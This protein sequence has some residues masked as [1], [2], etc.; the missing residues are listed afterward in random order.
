M[1]AARWHHLQA[2]F[3]RAVEL[4]GPAQRL[5][6]L[7]DRGVQEAQGLSS[8]PASAGGPLSGLG[9]IYQKPGKLDRA[10]A[11]LRSGLERRIAVF[12]KDNAETALHQ[13]EKAQQYRTELAAADSKVAVR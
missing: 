1:D 13:P 2:M 12:G 9:S 7:L 6:L 5:F 11:L 8:E 4:P 10:D 3:H